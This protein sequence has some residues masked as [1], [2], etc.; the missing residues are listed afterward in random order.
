MLKRGKRQK[1]LRQEE[2]WRRKNSMF[3]TGLKKSTV[4]QKGNPTLFALT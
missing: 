2:N 1:G 3:R 4:S